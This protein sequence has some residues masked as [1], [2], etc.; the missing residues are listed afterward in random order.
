LIA[1]IEA[2]ERLK[3]AAAAAQ[4]RAAVAFASVRRGAEEAAGVPARRRGRGVAAEVALARRDSP[5]RGNRHLGFAKALVHEMPHTLA[6]LESGVLSEWRATL[7][8]RE[9]ACLDIEDRRTLD[10]ELCGDPKQLEGLG[11]RR[12]AAEAR[13]IAYRLDP[14]AVVDRAARAERERTVTIRPAPDCMTYLTALLPMAQGV[15]V[16]AALTRAAAGCGDGRGRGQVMADTLVE[17]VTGRAAATAVPVAVNLVL[18]DE[19]LLAG[20]NTPASV[21]G[22]GPIPAAV[23]RQLI[24]AAARDPKSRASLRRLYQHPR[25]GA[26][27]G[28]ESRSR[29]FPAG[30][31]RFIALRD[32]TCRTPY[33]GAPIRHTDH[34]TP[35]ARGGPTSAANG[36]G[37]C[38]A[39]N[40]TKESPGWTVAARTGPEGAHTAILT[41]PTG[42]THRSTAPP[43]TGTPRRYEA[44]TLEIDIG[45]AL[46]THAA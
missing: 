10:A 22:Y 46:V 15:S 13:A 43:V 36:E 42:A 20:S 14:H 8:V 24:S 5:A 31:A 11:D 7:I 1:R 6:A 17:R 26:L 28:M 25:S 34:A 21:P 9:S 12:I 33:C 4:A 19:S 16:Y 41:S 37:L 29:L 18:S 32:Q 38:A 39:C 2:L 44:S 30:L 27:V 35:A 40:Y 23:A 45:I 3:S